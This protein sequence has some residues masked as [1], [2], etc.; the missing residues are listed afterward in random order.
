MGGGT[1][2]L[3]G[4]G[5]GGGGW[6]VNLPANTIQILALPV[7]GTAKVKFVNIT[8]LLNLSFCQAR[9][10]GLEGLGLPKLGFYNLRCQF[11]YC[12]S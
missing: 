1:I 7:L 10:G 6:G 2:Y 3:V 8:C 9:R 4:G 5:G 12:R 11:F